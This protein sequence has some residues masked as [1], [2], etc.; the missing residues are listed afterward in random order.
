MFRGS[1]VLRLVKQRH[2]TNYEDKKATQDALILPPSTQP[3][4]EFLILAQLFPAKNCSVAESHGGTSDGFVRSLR[5]FTGILAETSYEVNGVY[6]R[7]LLYQT[8]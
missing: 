5:G 3:K 2:N 4:C 8:L 6:R 1:A 7:S